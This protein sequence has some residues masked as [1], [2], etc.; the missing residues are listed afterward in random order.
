M[1][2]TLIF[3]ILFFGALTLI[4]IFESNDTDEEVKGEVEET[5][6]TLGYCK[7]FQRYALALAQENNLEVVNFGSSFEVLSKLMQGKIDY[8]VIGRRAY[9]FEIDDSI[10]ET[11]LKEYGWTLVSSEKNFFQYPEIV[12]YEIHTYLN[13]EEV[14]EFFDYKPK[15]FFHENI[16]SSIENEISLIHWDD[17]KDEFELVIPV[18]GDNKVEKFRNPMLYKHESAEPLAKETLSF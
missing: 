2:K 8:A 4:S 1:L 18:S 13:E 12:N 3:I 16:E 17:F 6:L 15:L 14:R 11:P 10:L 7:T 5:S 9:S